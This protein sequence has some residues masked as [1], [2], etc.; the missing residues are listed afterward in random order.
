MTARGLHLVEHGSGDPVLVLPGLTFPGASWAPV[1]ERAAGQHW[2]ALDLPGH[3]ASRA[4]DVVRPVELADAVAEAVRQRDLPPPL[5][6]GHSYG[7]LVAAAYAGRHPVRGLV[8]V[9]QRLD[10][11]GT[12]LPA[13]GLP[14]GGAAAVAP[15][16]VAAICASLHADAL[17]PAVRAHL[18]AVHRPGPE[19]V[20]P[21]LRALEG[22]PVAELLSSVVA[23]LHGS[24]IPWVDVHRGEPGE[25][26]R[27]QVAEGGASVQV[28]P[29]ASHCV[30]LEHPA[31]F[32]QLAAR[33]GEGARAT[34]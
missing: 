32:A 12:P 16:L 10:A 3:G 7:A 23:A 29:G 25:A 17:D 34:S 8:T 24:G 5:V 26:H 15:H 28:W 19:L 30:H 14:A 27:A 31:R 2:L 18:A 1:W 6:V 22:V 20:A 13:A 9:D 33:V 11:D 4:W 21:Y